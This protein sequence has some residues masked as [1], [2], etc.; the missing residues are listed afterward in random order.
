MSAFFYWRQNMKKLKKLLSLV[1]ST[2]LLITTIPIHSFSVSYPVLPQYEFSNFAKITSA[3]FYDSDTT[4][5][6]IQDLHNNKE[7]QD[8]IYKLLDSLNKKYGNLEV[9]I[10][11]ASLPVDY[12]KLAKQMSETELEALMNSLYENDK[13][14]GAE[15]FGYKNNKNHMP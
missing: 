9:Y 1:I 15:F 3:N 7:V 13:V 6:N 4:V 8:N 2:A 11:G 12:S 5:I 14:S 10:E